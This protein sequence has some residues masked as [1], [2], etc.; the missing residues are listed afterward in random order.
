MIVGQRDGVETAL[1]D[2]QGSRMGTEADDL[3]GVRLAAG[4]DRH[5]E[6]ADP[7]IGLCQD[8]GEGGERV[9]TGGDA[10]ARAVV[11]HDVAGEDKGELFG[12]GGAGEQAEKRNA[13]GH[14]SKGWPQG[15][16]ENSGQFHGASFSSHQYW[17]SP[18]RT[19]S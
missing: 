12:A 2:G 11:E 4:G 1:E 8:A 13:R 6:I 17:S 9:A 18:S 14:G 3:A 7:V 5:L 16:P 15:R 10:A 19:G